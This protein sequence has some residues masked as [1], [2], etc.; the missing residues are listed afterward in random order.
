MKSFRKIG[1]IYRG[2]ADCIVTGDADLLEMGAFDGIHIL[3]PAE[4][5]AQ[6]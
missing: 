5:L 4:F 3:R 6:L 2:D 1:P